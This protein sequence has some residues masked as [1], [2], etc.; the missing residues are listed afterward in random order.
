MFDLLQFLD[1]LIWPRD[2]SRG[3][4]GFAILF[5]VP[6]WLL[7]GAMLAGIGW[8]SFALANGLKANLLPCALLAIGFALLSQSFIVLLSLLRGMWTDK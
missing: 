3:K 6:I 4:F 2:W 1:W 5:I 7:F 8:S